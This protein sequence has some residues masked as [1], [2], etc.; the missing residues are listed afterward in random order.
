MVGV[1]VNLYCRMLVVN[2]F[3]YFKIADR[4]AKTTLVSAELHKPH[5]DLS[6]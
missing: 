1:L 5:H 3:V 6:V 2:S 4:P